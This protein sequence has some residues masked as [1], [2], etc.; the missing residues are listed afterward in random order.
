MLSKNYMD[1]RYNSKNCNIYSY[2]NIGYNSINDFLLTNSGTSGRGP[3]KR[4]SP[5]ITLTSCGNSSSLVFLRNLPHLFA[6]IFLPCENPCTSKE[7]RS[8]NY[9][10]FDSILGKQLD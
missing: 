6:W 2:D 7:E 1:I 4:M 3:I 5:L 10:L 9:V 8:S